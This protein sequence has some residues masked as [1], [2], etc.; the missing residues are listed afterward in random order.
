MKYPKFL[1][2]VTLAAMVTTALPVTGT[3]VY[4]SE[5]ETPKEYEARTEYKLPKG[6][7]YV[8]SDGKYVVFGDDGKALIEK[9]EEEKMET[10]KPEA[11]KAEVKKVEVKKTEVKKLEVKES[12]PQEEPEGKEAETPKEEKNEAKN[13]ESEKDAEKQEDIGKQ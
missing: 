4:A 11:Q 12:A 2:A 7:H 6:Y 10:K 13:R 9:S 3:A 8:L 5:K 1:Q